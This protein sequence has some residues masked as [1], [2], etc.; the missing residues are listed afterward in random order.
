MHAVRKRFAA[1]VVL[2]VL[3]LAGT[4]WA[5][6][7]PTIPALGRLPSQ[8]ASALVAGD[9][10]TLR[11]MCT[12]TGTVIDEFPPYLWTGRDACARFARAFAAVA[13]HARLTS[14]TA[15]TKATVVT[16]SP[17]RVYVTARVTLTPVVRG[18]PMPE[19][20]TWT[21]VLVRSP[22]G[23][24]IASMAWGTLPS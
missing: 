8:I 5:A 15:A 23:W 2:V 21:F 24:K 19:N 9:V 17:G 12:P 20:G 7:D 6:P 11:A 16:R 22:H 18:D 3:S 10:G 4:A 14:M 13:R 1:G